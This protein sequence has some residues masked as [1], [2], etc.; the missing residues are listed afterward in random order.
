MYKKQGKYK[1]QNNHIYLQN[2]NSVF[3]KYKELSPEL[4]EILKL[5]LANPK[6]PT[7]AKNTLK[8]LKENKANIII[9]MCEIKNKFK[10]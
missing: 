6:T 7:Q 5:P 10:I 1:I 9:K 3:I 4:I 8:A 2:E